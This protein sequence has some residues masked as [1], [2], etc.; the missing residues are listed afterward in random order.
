MDVFPPRFILSTNGFSRGAELSDYAEA[1]AAALLNGARTRM[2][3]VRVHVTRETS[4]S[5][6]PS[7]AARAVAAGRLDAD[8]VVHAKAAEP[9]DAIRVV[10]ENL[11]RALASTAEARKSKAEHA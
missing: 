10:F 1:K 7:F 3:L 11:E 2:Y 4:H 8:H 6:G 9:C 5:T